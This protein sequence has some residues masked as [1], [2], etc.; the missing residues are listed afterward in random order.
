MIKILIVDDE[1]DILDSLKK[2]LNRTGFDE[3]TTVNNPKIAL[4]IV[5]AVKFD[6]LIT[7]IDMPN[8]NGAELVDE[9]YKEDK[10]IK[11]IV[12]TV[13]ENY[14]AEDKTLNKKIILILEKPI[15]L[16]KLA[17]TL[18]SI[19]KQTVHVK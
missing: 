10:S 16:F 14:L 7:D 9:I 6:V 15:N 11:I 4:E 12:M 2:A 13:I 5:K 17:D 18:N 8:L 3:I 1:K 19:D